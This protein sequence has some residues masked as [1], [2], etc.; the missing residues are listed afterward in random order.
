MKGKKMENKDLNFEINIEKLN[1]FFEYTKDAFAKKLIVNLK[2]RL[3]KNNKISF[4]EVMDFNR[5]K[6]IVEKEKKRRDLIEKQKIPLKT[7]MY[8]FKISLTSGIWRV[9]EIKGDKLLSELD[10]LIQ[11]AFD[12]EPGHL[13]E[14]RFGEY[15][16]GPECDEWEEIFDEL[17]NVKISSIV[18]SIGL[19]VNDKGKY[20][21]DFGE[22]IIH[23]IELVEIK[24]PK[25]N[26][27]Y[28]II[29]G[30]E[31][32]FKCMD[33]KSANALLWCHSCHMKLCDDCSGNTSKYCQEGHY[34]LLSIYHDKESQWD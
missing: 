29:T 27:K 10:Y 7:Y 33:C 22:N 4:I 19:K 11:R 5:I 2:E 3:E 6:E 8:V 23:I 14:F 13:Y 12:H 24:E 20:I 26:Q 30:N 31:R 21:Y 32:L 15:R 9:I 1:E 17:T 18:N 28:P 34:P 25:E 16:F